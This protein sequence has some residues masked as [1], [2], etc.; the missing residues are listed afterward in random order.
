[1][2]FFAIRRLALVTH[3]VVFSLRDLLTLVW[4]RA[5]PNYPGMVK[6]RMLFVLLSVLYLRLTSHW[7]TS[8]FTGCFTRE[9]FGPKRGLITLKVRWWPFVICLG[10][11]L[12]VY[13]LGCSLCLNFLRF[14]DYNGC[15]WL[16]CYC[17]LL[18]VVDWEVLL[19][20]WWRCVDSQIFDL[21]AL[22]LKLFFA[23]RISFDEFNAFKVGFL[24]GT[25]VGTLH[26][27]GKSIPRLACKILCV[28]SH[29]GW[30]EILVG[31]VNWELFAHFMRLWFNL[32]LFQPFL[33]SAV[34]SKVKLLS[35]LL[36]KWATASISQPFFYFL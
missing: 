8:W 4:N 9:N 5:L 18:L 14:H 34:R 35:L 29:W 33:K 24:D 31:V 12:D 26:T 30:G 27:W 28:I 11:V 15:I 7:G 22:I 21:D 32:T 23:Q 17:F 10:I 13:V 36:S 6:L 16:D 2:I 25:Q 20:I 1:M 3:F 19:Q